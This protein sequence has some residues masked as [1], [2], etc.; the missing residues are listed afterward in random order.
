[1]FQTK[2]NLLFQETGTIIA[3]PFIVFLFL[4]PFLGFITDKKGQKGYVLIVGFALLF[5]AHVIFFN[6]KPCPPND[7]CYE[8]IFPMTLIGM[9]NTMI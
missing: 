8:G 7:K 2:F 6:F 9:A 4:G 5:F 3:F 1:M